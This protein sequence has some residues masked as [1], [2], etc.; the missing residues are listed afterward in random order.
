[1][2][3]LVA[4]DHPIVRQGLGRLLLGQADVEVAGTAKN[5]EE[6][7]EKAMSLHPDNPS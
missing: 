4:D 3:V 7:L 6:A 1:M 2:R 5:G